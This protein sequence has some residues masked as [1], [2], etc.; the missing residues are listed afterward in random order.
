MN[1]KRKAFMVVPRCLV[2]I[3]LIGL[4]PGSGCL[5]ADRFLKIRSSTSTEFF[6]NPFH[7]FR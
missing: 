6:E 7:H 3:L 4:W 1:I 2:L 5:A